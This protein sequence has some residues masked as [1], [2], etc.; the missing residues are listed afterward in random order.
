MPQF[1][2]TD[3]NLSTYVW[4]M[5]NIMEPG[6]PYTAIEIMGML[7]I[8]SRETFRRHY[9]NP[10]LEHGDVVM[11]IP[12]KPQSRNQRYIRKAERTLTGSTETSTE[13]D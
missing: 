7:G 3:V 12:E 2:K 1:D 8:R 11:T 10:A 5:L 6:V 13:T 9:M 4:K